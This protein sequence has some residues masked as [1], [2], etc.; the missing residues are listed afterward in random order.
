MEERKGERREA[1]EGRKNAERTEREWEL[2]GDMSLILMLYAYA[3]L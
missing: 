2:K 3:D 1:N